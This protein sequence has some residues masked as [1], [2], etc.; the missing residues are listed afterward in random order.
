MV[1]KKNQN[2]WSYQNIS[3]FWDYMSSNPYKNAIYFTRLVGKGII[4]F[5]KAKG[6]LKGKVLDFGCGNGDILRY[7]FEQN[8][9][10]VYALDNS[11]SSITYVKNK[12]G[13]YLRDAI[14]VE[15]YPSKYPSD[16]FDTI[17]LIETI[18]H[19]KDNMLEDV[20]YEIKRLLKDKG[21]LVVTTPHDEDLDSFQYYC[22]FCTAEFHGM[23]HMRSFSKNSITDLFLKHGFNVIECGATNFNF[24]NSK[25]RYQKYLFKRFLKSIANKFGFNLYSKDPHLYI[26]VEN[27]K[28]N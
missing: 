22:P 8:I 17:L 2:D 16:S 19:L 1:T 25:I 5:F 14:H 27:V 7:L 12:Y 20:I 9:N 13:Q 3:N 24:T 21:R 18:E 10:D 4:N 11:P 6:H 23:Q 26:I 28:K 15:S